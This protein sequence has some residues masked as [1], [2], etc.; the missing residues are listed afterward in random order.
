MKQLT[1]RRPLTHT[2]T[3]RQDRHTG[4]AAAVWRDKAG[5][6]RTRLLPGEFNSPGSRTAFERLR[7]DVKASATGR[8]P[9]APPLTVAGLLDAYEKYAKGHYKK[10]GRPTSTVW[11]VRTVGL[12][13]CERHAHRPAAAFGPL[14]LKETLRR[15]AANRML[16]TECNRRLSAVK[17]VFKW[18]ASEEL[19]PAAVYQALATVPGL[20]RGRTPARE[21]T[22]VRPVEDVVVDATLP[23]LTRHV[24]GLVEFQ[25]LTGCRPGEA[26]GVRLC[27]VDAAGPVWLY[28]PA[29]HKTAHRGKARVIPVGPRAQEVLRGFLTADPAAHLFAPRWAIRDVRARWDG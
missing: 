10:N 11:L 12:A 23:F 21:A 13:L 24:R 17:Q 18:A 29:D 27:D 1:T 16:R 26:C 6:R 22:P 25:R 2:P 14:L 28:T 20:H 15:W 4:R 3:Y 7:A 19:V 8:P 9:K 5:V